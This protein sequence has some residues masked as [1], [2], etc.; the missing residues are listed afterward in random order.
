MTSAIASFAT[1][2][3]AVGAATDNQVV[4]TALRIRQFGSGTPWAGLMVRYVDPNNYY[5]VTVRKSGE[6]SLRKITN[7]NITVLGSVP[8]PVTLAPAMQLRLEVIGT[9]LRVFVDNALVLERSDSSI[10]RGRSGFVTYRAA[11]SYDDY[12]AYQP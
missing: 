7:G 8:T 2:A 12:V 11:A 1:R 10:A 6:T 9:Q 3:V 4:Q 5:Y